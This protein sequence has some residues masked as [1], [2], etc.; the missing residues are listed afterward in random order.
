MVG[1]MGKRSKGEAGKRGAADAWDEV[2]EGEGVGETEGAD[3]EG[4]DTEE[5]ALRLRHDG[6]TPARQKQFIE[7]LG[8][9]G[10]VRDAC[11]VA[12]V[13][14]TTAYRARGRL[15]EGFARQWE[16]ALAMASSSLEVLAWERAVIGIEEPVVSAG[17]LV[18]TRMKRSDSLF[19]M[20][21]QASNT[22]K[23][24]RLGRTG[25]TEIQMKKRLLA[26]I[27]EE[28]MARRVRDAVDD[29]LS[30]ED[31]DL[32]HRFEEWQ[33]EETGRPGAPHFGSRT[34][35]EELRDYFDNLY[36]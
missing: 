10:C 6:F 5:S 4:A 26:E 18:C 32:L 12:G 30:N 1:A 7:T 21:L 35:E 23:F 22:E 9:T 36:K 20:L 27:T 29:K 17:K 11:R 3:T 14:T 8:Q 25:E 13:S 2:G 19:R 24:G 33:V 15:G 31:R 28:E 16:A 34:E